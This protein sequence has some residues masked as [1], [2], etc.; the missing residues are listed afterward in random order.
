MTKSRARARRRNAV[1]AENCR[2]H[3]EPAPA[4]PAGLWD[5]LPPELLDIILEQCCAK[6]LAMLETSCSFFRK[7]KKI[8]TVAETRLRAIPRAKGTVPDPK[9]VAWAHACMLTLST[10]ACAHAQPAVVLC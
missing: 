9:C 10:A 6:K 5:L 2:A 3:E 1:V 8:A 4:R 7:T